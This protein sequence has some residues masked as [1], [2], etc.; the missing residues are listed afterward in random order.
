MYKKSLAFE[1]KQGEAEI[2]IC[3]I[4]NSAGERIFS[5]MAPPENIVTPPNAEIFDGTY[6]FDGTITFGEDQNAI[7]DF[8]GRVLSWGELRETLTPDEDDLILSQQEQ[9]ISTFKVVLN[10]AD[11]YFSKLMGQENMINADVSVS[12]GYRDISKD[13]FLELFAGKVNNLTLT[14]DKLI[15]DV[16]AT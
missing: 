14:A 5:T 15:L 3:R 4:I 2:V 13:D 16:W 6:L 8:G 1:Q 7:L 10:N 9:E 12:V 11:K